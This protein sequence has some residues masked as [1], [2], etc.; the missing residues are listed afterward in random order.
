[1]PARAARDVERGS[2]R[3]IRDSIQ[4]QRRGRRVRPLVPPRETLVPPQDAF[5]RH[6][7]SKMA[8]T[9]T[10]MFAGSDAIPTALRPPIPLSSPK[11]STMSSLNPF[12]T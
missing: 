11:I 1:M 7:T 9:S 3:H 8:S 2:R 10:G 4:K 5:F 12:T 6:A